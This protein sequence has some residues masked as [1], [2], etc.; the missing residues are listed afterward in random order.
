MLIP[1][2]GFGGKGGFGSRYEKLHVILGK[3]R[4]RVEMDVVVSSSQ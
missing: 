4:R 1:G 2:V 3:E